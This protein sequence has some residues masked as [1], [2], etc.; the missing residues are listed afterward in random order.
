MFIDDNLLYKHQKRCEFIK[1]V[2]SVDLDKIP[3]NEPVE[4]ETHSDNWTEVAK[5][6][7]RE[8]RKETK[9]KQKLKQKTSS[10]GGINR[11]STSRDNVQIIK[12]LE[13]TTYG[14]LVKVEMWDYKA[15][16]QG[17]KIDLHPDELDPE[18]KRI[19]K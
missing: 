10:T 16:N 12:E 7:S 6:G 3:L 9:N 13:N 14:I 5:I 11:P 4:S 2:R 17:K 19:E 1:E 8:G 18:S 15:S